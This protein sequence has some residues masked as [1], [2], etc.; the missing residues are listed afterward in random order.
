ADPE[1]SAARFGGVS[2]LHGRGARAD[3]RAEADGSWKAEVATMFAP[4]REGRVAAREGRVVTWIPAC[5]GMTGCCAEGGACHL[6]SRLRG[7]DR[8]LRGKGGLPLGFPPA[9]E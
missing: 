2:G 7:N 9:R 8:L 3:C 6:D 5:A 4:A 1:A